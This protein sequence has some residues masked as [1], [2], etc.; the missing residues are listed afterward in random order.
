MTFQP[1]IPVVGYAG[2]AFLTRTMPAQQ[3]AMQASPVIR[4]DEEYFRDRITKI[5]SGRELVADR[6]LL[7]IALESFGLEGDVG[8]RAFI[9]KILDEGTADPKALANRLADKRYRSLAEAFDFSDPAAP[10]TRR[11]GFADEILS[12]H[13]RRRFEA[14]VGETDNN[15]RLALN[16]ERELSTL[17][18][19]PGSDNA[20]WFTIMGNPPLREVVE[21]ALGLPKSFGRINLDQQ[22]RT[23]K[24][25][26]QRGFGAATV[27]QFADPAKM[28]KLVRDFLIR[29][30]AAVVTSASPALLMLQLMRR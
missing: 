24:Q 19:S 2:W 30:E 21:G 6:R 18:G 28:N 16:A 25:K 17:A 23:L 5:G 12:L 26:A 14:A 11:E 27:E 13:H 8:A 9:G 4:R 22:L 20:K 10:A 7:R 29:R 1:I 3:K 15:L